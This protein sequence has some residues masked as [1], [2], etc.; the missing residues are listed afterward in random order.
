MPESG[1]FWLNLL[2][3]A[4]IV[5]LLVRASIAAWL[6]YRGKYIITCPETEKPAAVDVSIGH[7]A[8]TALYG[9][10]QLRLADCSRWPEREHCGQECLAQLAESHDQCML[11]NVVASWYQGKRCVLCNKDL[12]SLKW[13]EHKPALLGPDNRSVEWKDVPPELLPEIFAKFRPLCWDCH[14]VE[15]FRRE[16]PEL[17][18]E[19]RTE[20][21][22][23]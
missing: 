9:N 15:T 13:P 4:A 7:A 23:H 16:R 19:N 5:F 14:V 20:R 1:Y 17:V 11:R 10:T 22:H 18:I 21:L 3:V 12:G 8:L 2:I 6:R